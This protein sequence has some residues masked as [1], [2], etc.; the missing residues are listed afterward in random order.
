M[1]ELKKIGVLSAAKISTLFGLVAGIVMTLYLWTLYTFTPAE[2]LASMGI[3][4]TTFGFTPGATII[5]LQLVIYFLVG[6]IG[7]L[8]YN[9]FA[10][11]VGGVKVD[12]KDAPMKK[13]ASKK[14]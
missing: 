12:L 2:I 13:K 8:L 1:Q 7:A 4:A 14:K 9:G 5:L 6:I 3:Q 10:K 11:L